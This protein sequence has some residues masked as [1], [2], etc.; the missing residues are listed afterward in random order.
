MAKFEV[1]KTYSRAN[2]TVKVVDRNE[3]SMKIQLNAGF[4]VRRKIQLWNAGYENED[5]YFFFD[6][7]DEFGIKASDRID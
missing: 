5:E 1:G 7:R 4:V 3:K 6:K 2:Q